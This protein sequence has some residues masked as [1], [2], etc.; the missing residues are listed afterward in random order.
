MTSKVEIRFVQSLVFLASYFVP[1]S[2]ALTPA[3]GMTHG[4]KK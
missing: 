1:C 3:P 2:K 4:L